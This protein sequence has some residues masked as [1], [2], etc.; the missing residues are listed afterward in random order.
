M[1]AAASVIE[2][3]DRS[4]L[5]SKKAKERRSPSTSVWRPDAATL[6]LHKQRQ[7]GSHN[8]PVDASI[9]DV[10]TYDRMTPYDNNYQIHCKLGRYIIFIDF[11]AD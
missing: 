5:Y 2:S 11:A 9:T 4:T 1:G 3:A 10:P 6:I 7:K 8:T